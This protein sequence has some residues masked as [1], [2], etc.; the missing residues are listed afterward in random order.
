MQKIEEERLA[1][2]A[3][4]KYIAQTEKMHSII[5]E[6]RAK[7]GVVYNRYLEL[8]KGYTLNDDTAQTLINI[9]KIVMIYINTQEPEAL[10]NELQKAQTNEDALKIFKKYANK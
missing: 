5:V 8:Y 9:Q 3:I 2:E 6:N 7:G 1:L 10:K 4:P